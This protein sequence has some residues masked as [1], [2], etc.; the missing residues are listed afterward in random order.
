VRIPNLLY[1]TTT[2]NNVKHVIWVID[3]TADPVSC[4]RWPDDEYS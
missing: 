3:L 1:G 2:A 4:Q